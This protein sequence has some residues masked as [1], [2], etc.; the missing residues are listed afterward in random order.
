MI[1]INRN[2]YEEYFLDFQDGELSPSDENLLMLFLNENPD[3]KSEIE[4]FE[5]NKIPVD[6][7][8][9]EN[10]MELKKPGILS[11]VTINNF[12][13]L[14]I[15]RMEG[16]LKRRETIEFD[17]FIAGNKKKKKE[18][19]LY[20]LTKIQP[21][22]FAVFQNKESLKKNEKKIFVLRKSYQ[23]I[24][25][26]ASIIILLAIYLFIPKEKDNNKLPVAELDKSIN[27]ENLPV[28]DNEVK[29]VNILSDLNNNKRNI[30]IEEKSFASEKILKEKRNDDIEEDEVI[31]REINQLAYLY[32][33]EMKFDFYKCKVDKNII[34]VDIDKSQEK[35]DVDKKYISFKS[36]L[37]GTFNKRILKK[38]DKNKI[39]F[40][41][42]AQASVEG[43]NKLTGSKMSLERLYDKK[44]NPNKTEFNSR[45]IA[46]SAPIKN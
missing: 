5:A 17:K 35:E 31:P 2:N 34:Y 29:N 42:I 41:D 44:G 18:Y 25:I 15:A 46:F 37:A 43:I 36:Y 6:S 4:L 11:G 32:P 40:F 13:E 10:K 45:L 27:V 30:N 20:K 7:T 21:D 16:D 14:C 23:W 24:S 19:Y 1:D 9:F 39:E 3:L 38:E 12:D 33:A 26:A 8:F 28:T 22:N